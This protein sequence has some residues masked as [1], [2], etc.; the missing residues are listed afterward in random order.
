MVSPWMDNGNLT[1]YLK[2]SLMLSERLRLV[3]LYMVTFCS[4]DPHAKSQL[5]DV[6]VGLE[7]RAWL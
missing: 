2:K 6:V 1:M 3:S 4:I 5:R 7:Y